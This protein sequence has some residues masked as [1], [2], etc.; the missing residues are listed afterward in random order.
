MGYHDRFRQDMVD[1]TVEVLNT[2]NTKHLLSILKRVQMEIP[3]HDYYSPNGD[4]YL[5]SLDD[6]HKRL[7]SVLATRE[8]VP[9][10]LEAKKI[11]QER[12]KAKK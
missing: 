11:R 2:F 8:H 9:N 3:T 7:K 12:A 10:K 4:E 5:E 6:Y 1:H